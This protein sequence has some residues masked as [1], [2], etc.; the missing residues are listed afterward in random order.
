MK[1]LNSNGFTK[2][3][4]T[5]LFSILMV[6]ATLFTVKPASAQV[7]VNIN[8]VSQPLW[9][10]ISYDYVEY[11]YLPEAEVYYY[12]PTSQFIYW[13]NS[14]WVYVYNMPSMYHINLFTTYKVVLNG[15]KPYMNHPMHK[16]KYGKYKSEKNKQM[17]IRDSQDKK[18]HG[19]KGHSGNSKGNDNKQNN[20]KSEN[21]KPDTKKQGTVKTDNSK[22]GNVKPNNA[23]PGNSKPGTKKP[24]G[25][26][27]K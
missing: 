17:A 21:T 14:N 8:I 15:Y 19:V 16:L 6:T 13:H 23:K 22:P 18:Y 1:T 25:K 20:T 4:F 9:G 26:K 5:L 27:G 7:S 24:G 10:P 2:I 12:V 11:Y 3:N